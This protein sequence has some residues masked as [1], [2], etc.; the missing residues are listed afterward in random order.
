MRI[1]IPWAL[2]AV[3][4]T[5]AG[6]SQSS[7]TASV[8]NNEKTDSQPIETVT[9]KKET[10]VGTPIVF[11]DIAGPDLAKQKLFYSENF[12]WDISADGHVS[13][14]VVSPLPGFLR[15]DPSEAMLYFG[16]ADVT[17]AL[18]K[19]AASG[20]TIVAPRFEVPGVV[21]LGM[22]K[23]PAGNRM[24]LVEMDGDRAKIPKAK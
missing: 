23:D 12:A 21:I 20:G 2:T 9:L 16:V 14:P 5:L 3:V 22:F 10:A 19:V 18:A 7:P 17:A 8:Q 24:G 6:C 1:R 15:T 4:L 11:F 13:V